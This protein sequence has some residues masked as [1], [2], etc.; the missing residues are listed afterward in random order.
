MDSCRGVDQRAAHLRPRTVW[1]LFLGACFL[2]FVRISDGDGQCGCG[3]LF[4]LISLPFYPFRV[5]MGPRRK[6]TRKEVLKG[7]KRKR[8]G[9]RKRGERSRLPQ[10][11]RGRKEQKPSAPAEAM[12]R[13]S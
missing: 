4:N 13:S 12:P 6:N 10:L 9:M 5:I 2:H 1:G 11:Q 7:K 8:R 3:R